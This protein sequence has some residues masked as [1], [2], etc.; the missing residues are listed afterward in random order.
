MGSAVSVARCSDDDA[1][2]A[3]D[4]PEAP[5]NENQDAPQASSSAG[6]AEVRSTLIAVDIHTAAAGS[7]HAVRR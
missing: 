5:V 2:G 6:Q 3:V 1:P 4:Q 7:C